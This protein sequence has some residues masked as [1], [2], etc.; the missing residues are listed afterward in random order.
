MLFVSNKTNLDLFSSITPAKILILSLSDLTSGNYYQL[1]I[2][3]THTKK[4]KKQPEL[5]GRST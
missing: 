2:I 1:P 4:K 3:I 5:S